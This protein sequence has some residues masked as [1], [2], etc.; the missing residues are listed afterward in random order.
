MENETAPTVDIEEFDFDDEF[1][2]KGRWKNWKMKKVVI[3]VMVLH[4]Y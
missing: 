2:Y 1:E 4:V 3:F